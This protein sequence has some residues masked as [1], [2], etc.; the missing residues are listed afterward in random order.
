MRNYRNYVKGY[1]H[2]VILMFELTKKDF[3]FRW[4]PNLEVGI[5]L[6][7]NFG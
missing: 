6:C 1:L 5:G 3:V 2:I 7:S 4:N